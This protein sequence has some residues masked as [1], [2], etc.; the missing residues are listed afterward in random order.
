VSL[1]GG[2]VGDLSGFAAS[3][4]LRGVTYLQLP[5][6]LLSMVDSSVGGKTAVN[7][8]FGKNLVGTFYHPAGVM[9]DVNLLKTLPKREMTAGL[10]E[11][12]KQAAIGGRELFDQTAQ[13]LGSYEPKRA[14]LSSD[15]LVET[16][17][18]HVAFKAEIVAGDERED[19]ERRDPRSRKILNFG[20]TFAHA[21]E[22]VT[23]YRYFRHGEAVGHGILFAAELSNLIDI[24]DANELN[25]LYDVV[26]R[27]GPL[28]TLRGI[29]EDDIL[30]AF[31]F[32]KKVIAG[33]NQWIL[34]RGIGS[35]VILS[36][37]DIPAAAVKRALRNIL[38]Q[39][40]D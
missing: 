16:V 39:A 15:S 21:L 29:A 40:E 35:P 4:Y 31:G 22:K 20:H 11:I 24:L 23:G 2:V 38:R 3:I 26:R 25:L 7:T 12:V 5:T 37:S 9:A 13:F 36:G 32:D 30:S 27:V 8:R 14:Q 34:L 18:S 10:C 33:S 1:G 19:P 17:R 28:P 6:T